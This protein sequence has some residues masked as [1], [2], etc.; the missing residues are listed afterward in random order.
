MRCIAINKLNNNQCDAEAL[1]LGVCNKHYTMKYIQKQKIHLVKELKP[2][3]I[4]K[5]LT[6]NRFDSLIVCSTECKRAYSRR[7]DRR[8]RGVPKTIICIMCGK[9]VKRDIKQ[10]IKYRMTCSKE[11]SNARELQLQKEYNAKMGQVQKNITA[12][13]KELSEDEKS[14]VFEQA[15]IDIMNDL[16]G[17]S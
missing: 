16:N 15:R 5:T 6:Y 13:F 1:L 10:K 14:E 9:V 8:A 2:C 17:R 4:C 3:K 12:T 7:R 11:C